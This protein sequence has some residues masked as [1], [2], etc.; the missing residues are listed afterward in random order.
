MRFDTPVFLQRIQT[1]E[2][3]T[4]TGDYNQDT[5]TEVKQYASV[6]S[7]GVDTLNLIYGELKQGSL[8]VRLQ[9]HYDKPFDRLRIGD[10]LYRVDMS[11]ML[12]RKQVFV[13]SEVQDDGK[14][15]N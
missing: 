11:R 2:Y 5:I 8:T 6:T 12:R 4:A 15:E 7:S 13:V 3:D 9:N 1:G 14:T 10:R